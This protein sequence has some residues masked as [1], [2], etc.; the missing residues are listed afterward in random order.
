MITKTL[1]VAMVLALVMGAGVVAATGTNSSQTTANVGNYL[2]S[3]N[4]TASTVTNLD[5]NSTNLNAGIASM[6]KVSAPSLSMPTG[7]GISVAIKM[8]NGSIIRTSDANLFLLFAGGMD[9]THSTAFVNL[10]LDH[11]AIPLKFKLNSSLYFGMGG[12]STQM[13]ISMGSVRAYGM[14]IEGIPV[15]VFG[16]SD[17]NLSSNGLFLNYTSTSGHM[18]L[19]I[20]TNL[21]LRSYLLDHLQNN[22]AFA[23]N[24]TTGLVSGD[25]LNFTFNQS[26]GII[27]GF[28]S[29]V[30]RQTVFSQIEVKGNGSLLQSGRAPVI[31][32][33]T[34]VLMGSLFA[35]LNNT[36][37]MTVHDNPSLESNFFVSNGTINFT[38]ATGITA[39][40]FSPR[41][42][43]SSF[44]GSELAT[45]SNAFTYQ[46]GG[47]S[48]N[49]NA[50]SHGV[51][52]SGNGFR[53]FLLLSQGELNVN[54]Q[55]VSIST[56]E[57]AHVAFVAPPGLQGSR[58]SDLNAVADGIIHGKVATQVVLTSENGVVNSQNMNYN[59]SVNLTLI[60]AA[61]GR[62][63][64]AVSSST[65][66]G[67]SIAVFV[68]NTVISNS[69]KIVVKF[70]STTVS[71]QTVN[72]VINSTDSLNATYST[73]SVSGGFVVIVHIPHFSN[74]TIEITSAQ[75]NST[76][77]IGS[78]LSSSTGLAIVGLVVVVVAVLAVAGIRRQRH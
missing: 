54:G 42:I 16:T 32:T 7:N 18:V 70:D 51:Y 20:V 68:P 76:S 43:S 30:D 38:L 55:V 53:G 28:N 27:T 24:I 34:P 39:T 67:T 4:G 78:F 65:H 44:T 50:G 69:S 25:F 10:T 41:G 58:N 35:Y 72:L 17:A 31:T 11:K 12:F 33:D 66:S 19:G 8:T 5:Y 37:L 63:N 23:Y 14:D 61:S 6:I 48:G 52:L 73:V 15:I 36:D 77:T 57:L 56:S 21:S 64:L 29:T 26:T 3:Y 2:F 75:T 60:N 59:A 62:V 74:H 9:I 13:G 47:I 1:A 45:N 22:R 40:K 71:A 49:V 46:A